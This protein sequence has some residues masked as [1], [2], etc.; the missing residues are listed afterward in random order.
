MY[1][2]T[3]GDLSATLLRGSPH[4]RPHNTPHTQELPP[5][6]RLQNGVCRMGAI[7]DWEPI[8]GAVLV[9]AAATGSCERGALRPDGEAGARE[10]GLTRGD[11]ADADRL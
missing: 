1:S 10:A 5:S 2:R 11:A 4:S 8:L 3:G 6:R 7:A 9:H